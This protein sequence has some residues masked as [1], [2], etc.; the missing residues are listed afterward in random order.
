MFK[1]SKTLISPEIDKTLLNVKCW[2]A[3]QNKILMQEP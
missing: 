2:P 1:A 3:I